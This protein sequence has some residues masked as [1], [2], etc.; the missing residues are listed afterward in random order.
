MVHYKLY[1]FNGRG[2][3]ELSRLIFAAAGQKYED[4]RFERDEWPQ[5]KRRSPLGHAPYLEVVQ[6]GKV[7][8]LAQSITIGK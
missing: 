1:Y 2:R 5:Y 3:A 8:Q 7:F 6:D 4:I